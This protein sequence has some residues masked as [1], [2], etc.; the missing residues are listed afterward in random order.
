MQFALVD[1]QP[2]EAQRGLSATCPNCGHPLVA[3]C[4][5][6]RINHWAHK[7]TLDCDPWWENETEWHRGW[8]GLFPISWQEV[9]HQAE[10]GEK[11][12]AD[13]KTENGWVIEFQHSYLNPDERRSRNAFYQKLIWVVNGTRRKRDRAQMITAWNDAGR[14]NAPFVRRLYPDD[15]ALLRDWG[16]T[17]APIFFDCGPDQPLWWLLAKGQSGLAYV[18]AWHRTNLIQILLGQAH[19]EAQDFE[20]FV[21]ELATLVAEYERALRYRR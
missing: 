19:H 20:S 8:K 1:G 17:T 4:G 5:E 6:H 12:I 9:I 7:G 3:K 14:T 18:G 2:Q 21:K 15:C 16:E 11:H 10:S 13:V